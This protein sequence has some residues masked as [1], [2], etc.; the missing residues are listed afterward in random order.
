MRFCAGDADQLGLDAEGRGQLLGHV[1]VIALDLHIASQAT[2]RAE[3][4]EDA[5]LEDAGLGDVFERVGTRPVACR[6]RRDRAKGR[7]RRSTAKRTG[8][9]LRLAS[10]T[11]LS[12]D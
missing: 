5:D 9:R 10:A 11:S 8:V 2:R 3:I 1:D 7:G 4:L 6:R 12:V